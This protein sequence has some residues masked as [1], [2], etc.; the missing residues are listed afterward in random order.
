M[1]YIFLCPLLLCLIVCSVSFKKSG[2]YSFLF[3]ANGI[4]RLSVCLLLFSWLKLPVYSPD[5]SKALPP[6]GQRSLQPVSTSGE[7]ME[8][9]EEAITML[10]VLIVC[11]RIWKTA[12]Q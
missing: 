11:A 3:V 6:A 1:D 9:A 10:I 2:P 7:E 8:G 12:N 4:S 5:G